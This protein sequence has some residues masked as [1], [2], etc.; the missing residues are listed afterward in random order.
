M[1]FV[2]YVLALSLA[3]GLVVAPDADALSFGMGPAV[4]NVTGTQYDPMVVVP[5]E[6]DHFTASSVSPEVIGA[7]WYIV[8]PALNQLL[9]PW[10]SDTYGASAFVSFD[11]N[12]LVQ[13]MVTYEPE[14]PGEKRWVAPLYV[15]DIE[16][17]PG[18]YGLWVRAT[19]VTEPAEPTGGG[20]NI[21]VGVL[22]RGTLHVE[23]APSAVPEPASCAL[24]ALAVGGIGAMVRRRKR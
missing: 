4:F 13:E 23:G 11:P 22:A 2:G 15:R 6:D 9:D 12:V 7:H 8:N 17:D 21:G 18:D 20:V 19:A 3:G 16:L 5:V 24:L 14:F 1:R 10:L